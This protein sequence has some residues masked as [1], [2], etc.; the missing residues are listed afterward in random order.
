MVENNTLVSSYSDN[1]YVRYIAQVSASV[2]C[3][4][5]LV[6][7]SKGCRASCPGQQRAAALFY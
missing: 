7:G 5:E 4:S 3:N 2:Q 1:D 6:P